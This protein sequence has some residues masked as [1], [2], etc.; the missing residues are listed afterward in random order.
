LYRVLG[1]FLLIHKVVVVCQ[2]TL[3]GYLALWLRSFD[4][5]GRDGHTNGEG[6][7]VRER[8]NHKDSHQSG[9]KSRS[10][11][12]GGRLRCYICQYE[13]H[14]K[15]N[16]SKNNH[17]KSTGYVKKD[18]Q[19]SSSGSIYYGDLAAKDTAIS[20]EDHALLLLTYLPSSYDN[21]M[22]TLPYGRDTLKLEDVLVTLNSR[23]LLKLTEAKGDGG[24]GLYVKGRS[25]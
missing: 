19:P 13:D 4:F 22:E 10:K 15:R 5:G 21:F 14:L 16:C 1:T 8:T 17:K 25:I 20:D 6:L 11:S 24:E 18:D 12:Q 23:E 7:Y 2:R 3:C 9:E